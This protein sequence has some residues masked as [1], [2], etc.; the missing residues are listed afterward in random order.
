M[1]AGAMRKAVY[2][3]LWN[4]KWDTES[5]SDYESL[6]AETNAGNSYDTPW[7]CRSKRPQP[8]D[9]AYMKRT[10]GKN[11]GLFA[12]G[13]VVGGCYTR[14]SDGTQCVSLRL[15]TFLPLGN[16]ISHVDLQHSPLDRT[17]WKPQAS[18]MRV[19]PESVDALDRLW[20]SRCGENDKA[21]GNTQTIVR[22]S[23]RA[24]GTQ[25]V[26]KVFERIS[27]IVPDPFERLTA[28]RQLVASAAYA[29]EIAPATWGVTLYPKENLFR[30]NVGPV[31]VL[32]VGNG[33]RLNCVGSIS[34][35]PF[36]GPNFQGTTYRSVSDPQ[37]AFV[38]SLDAFAAVAAD[39]QPHHRRFI[40]LALQKKDGT[41]F[42]GS[43]YRKSH[44]EDLLAYARALVAKQISVESTPWLFPGDE[45]VALTEG[46][47]LTV[48]VNAY[49]RNP[50]AR[51]R[52]LEHYGVSCVICGFTAENVYGREAA[53]FIHVHHLRPL[54]EIG[55]RYV[56]D[57]IVDLR[58]V[59]PNCHAVIHSRKPAYSLEEVVAMVK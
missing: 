52:C 59:C 20:I 29:E 40:E 39:L 11:N 37:C 17:N 32:V 12:R 19:H 56:V 33:I 28:L 44:S 51:A 24:Q 16:E 15:H 42:R 57:P 9:E 3:F 6:V 18:G 31:E 41:P 47:R 5:F 30:L 23:D 4:P 49:E 25:D 54:S 55:A 7:I 50:K 27:K 46:A 2:L 43:S 14:E 26:D 8:G 1:K 45:D 48:R 53:G 13:E 36:I 10:G 34:E 35:S 21:N 38:G 58:P 22:P